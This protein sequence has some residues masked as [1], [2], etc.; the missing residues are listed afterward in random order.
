MMCRFNLEG[1]RSSSFWQKLVEDFYTRKYSDIL[2]ADDTEYDTILS[3]STSPNRTKITKLV[4]YHNTSMCLCI[5]FAMTSKVRKKPKNFKINRKGRRFKKNSLNAED[6]LYRKTWQV[7]EYFAENLIRCHGLRV[8]PV[9]VCNTVRL[10]QVRSRH[11]L[12]PSGTRF[13]R[14]SGL[15]V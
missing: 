15:R 1:R 14:V 6:L 13:A 4:L 10:G 11:N 9:C 3:V 12:K 2:S 8:Y 7:C 5:V